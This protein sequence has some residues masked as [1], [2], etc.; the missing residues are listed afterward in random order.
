RELRDQAVSDADLHGA[1]GL[2]DI[3]E[4]RAVSTDLS[5]TLRV[6]GADGELERMGGRRQRVRLGR[7]RVAILLLRAGDAGGG[8]AGHGDG[9]YSD[10][11][12]A[13]DVLLGDF[14]SMWTV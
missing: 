9:C 1:A 7:A 5:E 6:A 4:L 11:F 2:C 14:R 13:H 8:E 12:R 10:P 3:G